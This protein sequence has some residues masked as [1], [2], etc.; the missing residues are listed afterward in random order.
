MPPSVCKCSART[1]DLPFVFAL[2]A[3]NLH[4]QFFLRTEAI[5]TL[6]PLEWVLNTPMHHRVHHA[7][8]PA[9]LDCNFGGVLIVFDRLFGTFV[10]ERSDAPIRYGLVHPLGSNNPFVIA[11]GEWKQLTLDMRATP[12]LCAALRVACGRP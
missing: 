4:Y 8:N 10:G 12:N 3:I 7:S 1:E 11:F 6:G 9:Y 5:G 2:L